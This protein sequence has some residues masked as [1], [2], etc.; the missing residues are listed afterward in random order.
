MEEVRGRILPETLPHA[1]QM[2]DFSLKFERMQNI[3]LAAVDNIESWLADIGFEDVLME[4]KRWM[5]GSGE[6]NKDNRGIVLGDWRAIRLGMAKAGIDLGMSDVE[7]EQL[8]RDTEE[9]LRE[10]EAYLILFDFTARKL[11]S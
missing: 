11:V 6:E 9:D 5:L 2:M 1:S 3:D 10:D 4:T 8:F 7:W